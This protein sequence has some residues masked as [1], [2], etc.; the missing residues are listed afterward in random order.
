M[1]PERDQYTQIY[2]EQSRYGAILKRQEQEVHKKRLKNKEDKN[3]EQLL[4][5]IQT[6]LDDS[7]APRQKVF[8]AGLFP[9]GSVSAVVAA[10]GTGKTWFLQL[11]A[12]NLSVGG[13]VFDGFTEEEKPLKSLI[14]AGE[15]GPDL[16][17]Q[18]AYETHWQLNKENIVIVGLVDAEK[19]NISLMLDKEDGRKHIEYFVEKNKPD[20][21]FFDTF[22]SF[23]NKNENKSDDMKPLIRFLS[24]LAEKY[25]MAV[26]LMHHTRKSPSKSK[27]KPLTLDDAIGSS[28][29]IRLISVIIA[30]EAYSAGDTDEDYLSVKAQSINEA[31]KRAEAKTMVV[32]VLKTWFQDFNPFAFTILKEDDKTRVVIDLAPTFDEKTK[33]EIQ[34]LLLEYV[35]EAYGAEQWFKSSDIPTEFAVDDKLITI[36]YRHVRRLLTIMLNQGKLRK[37]GF[38]RNTFYQLLQGITENQDKNYEADRER[39]KS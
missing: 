28:V 35:R 6:N 16:L 34:T 17:F 7:I 39:I 2:K 1:R 25:D 11:L 21:I 36:S 3:Y 8:I 9:R 38:A 23:H 10:P 37:K 14:F 18:R 26:V 24:T 22:A 4:A 29:L 33:T 27:K 20:I 13:S 5:S 15:A 32:K 19:K 12:S 30:I 31:E